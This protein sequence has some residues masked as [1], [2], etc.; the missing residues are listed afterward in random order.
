M[1]GSTILIIAAALGMRIAESRRGL[2]MLDS[3]RDAITAAST[4]RGRIILRADR[5]GSTA[6]REVV[7]M[8]LREARV[9]RV[10]DGS[11]SMGMPMLDRLRADLRSRTEDTRADRAT[12]ADLRDR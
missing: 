10:A 4:R 3:A 11:T 9:R 8:G 2:T 5:A 1:R 7:L 12:A 6:R